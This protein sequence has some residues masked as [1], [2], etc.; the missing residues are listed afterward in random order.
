MY[1]QSYSLDTRKR[2]FAPAAPISCIKRVRLLVHPWQNRLCG[3]CTMSIENYLTPDD[4]FLDS[5]WAK[6]NA[7]NSS[8]RRSR[9]C[10]TWCAGH[11]PHVVAWLD[12]FVNKPIGDGFSATVYGFKADGGW[13]SRSQNQFEW[14]C[15]IQTWRFE[16]L[17]TMPRTF[18][19]CKEQY[20]R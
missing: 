1:E 12:N 20:L 2:T 9:L 14:H 17:V 11:V 10:I 8:L 19:E 6:N 4:N 15:Q 5:S 13:R 7:I 18:V 3:L 16:T